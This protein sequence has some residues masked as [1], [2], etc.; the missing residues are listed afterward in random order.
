MAILSCTPNAARPTAT[1]DLLLGTSPHPRRL[2]PDGQLKIIS[3]TPVEDLVVIPLFE[4]VEI[5][6]ADIREYFHDEVIARGC[7]RCGGPFDQIFFYANGLTLP[8]LDLLAER[9]NGKCQRCGR[10][11]TVWGPDALADF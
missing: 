4:F 3:H 7:P 9:G 11:S 8:A 1:G 2:P 5:P 10:K 6:P